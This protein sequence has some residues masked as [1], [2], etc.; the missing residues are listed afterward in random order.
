MKTNQPPEDFSQDHH[1]SGGGAPD[2]EASSRRIEREFARPADSYQ[3]NGLPLWPYTA[4]SEILLSQAV[5]REDSGLFEK[6]IFIFLHL[7][8]GEKTASADRA[9]HAVP[10]AWLPRPQFRAALLDWLDGLGELSVDDKIAAIEL[11]EAMKA[12]ARD[13]AVMPVKTCGGKKKGARSRPRR[14]S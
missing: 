9:R 4:G 14:R 3:F 13:A 7:K 6:F 12:P 2:P 10:L 5:D 8:R 1:L 11:V